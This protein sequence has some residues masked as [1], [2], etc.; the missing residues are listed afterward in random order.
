MKSW[1]PNSLT[2]ANLVC[3]ILSIYFSF[4]QKYEVAAFLIIIALVADG[5]DGRVARALN[6]SGDLGKELDSLCDAVSFG[7]APAFLIYHYAGFAEMDCSEPLVWLGIVGALVFAMCGVFRLARF[8]TMTDIVKGYFLGMPIPAG[9][10]LVATYVLSD[11]AFSPTVSL[12]FLLVWGPMM[13]STFKFPDF[14]GGDTYRINKIA[15]GIS[16][17]V[18]VFLMTLSLKAVGFAVF[19]GYMVFGVINT[20]LT[21]SKSQ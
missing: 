21:A 8:N 16:V 17:I 1:A 18:G 2:L 12:V 20:F 14:K 9:G 4:H 10:C 19:F 6:V 13:V 11:L 5:L 15:V 3:G 7:V